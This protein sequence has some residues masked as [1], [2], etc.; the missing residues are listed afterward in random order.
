MRLHQLSVT[1]FGPFAGTEV[2]DFDLLARAG[3]FL[4]TGPTGAGKT[5]VLDAVCFALYGQVPGARSGAPLRSEH[6]SADCAT[7]VE[8]ELTIRGRRFRVQR[9][10]AWERAKRKGEGTT[11]QPAKI[12]LTEFSSQQWHTVSTRL[13]EAGQ[14]LARLIG[15]SMTQFC[16]VV[17]LPQGQFAEFLR[18]PAE[19]RREL[20]ENLFDTSRFATVEMWFVEARRA[21]ARA[22]Q[23]HDQAVH[24]VVARVAEAVQAE[25]PA[26]DL[27]P[28]AAQAWLTELIDE[29][30]ARS[31][32]AVDAEELAGQRR[33]QAQAALL[34]AEQ[35]DSA[36]QRFAAL[37][38]RRDELL[39][40]AP[41]VA[42][43][44]EEL[45]TARRAAPVVPLWTETVRLEQ[46]LA[47]AVG[48]VA[49]VTQ[50]LSAQM[51][52][53]SATLR[54]SA[55][56]RATAA[57]LRA[58]T[59]VLGQLV[60][61]EVRA[62]E[63]TDQLAEF[64][65][66]I[67]SLDTQ[68]AELAAATKDSPAIVAQLETEL[69]AARRAQAQL[70]GLETAAH[71]ANSCLAAAR[72]R[73]ELEVRWAAQ[74]DELRIAV[75]G[76]QAAR[77]LALDLRESRLQGMAAELA[78]TLADETPCCVCGSTEHPQPAQASVG[79]ATKADEQAADAL[80]ESAERA[81][82]EVLARVT[83]TE[84][85]LAEARSLAADRSV[86]DLT[87]LLAEAEAEQ[88]VAR[89]SAATCSSAEDRLQR[90]RRQQEL[91]IQQRMALDAE[92]ER[93]RERTRVAQEQLD[94]LRAQ[95]TLARGP[96]FS[97][98]ARIARIERLAAD[99]EALSDALNGAER[100]RRDLDA[101]RTRAEEAAQL[102][103]IPDLSLVPQ[104]IR[105]ERR[106]TELEEQRARHIA[107]LASVNELLADPLLQS[108]AAH[109]PIEMSELRLDAERAEVDHRQAV[110][111]RH[112]AHQ[113][114]TALSRLST[115]IET[116][117]T[118]RLPLAAHFEI[119][120][121]L[122]RLVE[123][124]STDNRLRMSLAAYVLAAR[125]E[126]VAAAASERLLAMS[127]GRYSLLHSDAASGRA[128]RGGLN[129]RVFDAWTGSDRDPAT[130]SGGESF[131]AS[132]ALALGLADVVTG[133]AGGSLLETL[134][135]DEGF[136][137]L[138]E[139]TLDDVMGL[140]DNLR[141][142]GRIIGIVSHV[143][144]LRQRV[145]TQLQIVKG[146]RGSTICQ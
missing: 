70:A 64:E 6:A 32:L 34:A 74:R 60:D 22:L 143:A 141:D 19:R 117:L 36:R 140:L 94:S 13:D 43:F 66:T 76:A 91:Q 129:L 47:E 73:D 58:E 112:G 132:L 125:L 50:G 75:D 79:A 35:L 46:V 33:Q 118:A 111:E 134:F 65:R 107:E 45:E 138:D 93:L 20:L 31:L 18:A 108:A 116:L 41:A 8:L 23:N 114:T 123:G 90:H 62:E 37:A 135:V 130:L 12:L 69:D 63:L 21:A 27:D 105:D 28:S 142:G 15:L 61:H 95:L 98:R 110:G 59:G 137:S 136:G 97:V 39:A 57:A 127:S 86:R 10:P 55:D 109:G 71:S 126:Q 119:V 89:A 88:A 24:R 40:E 72:R 121:H 77:Q 9:S 1:A 124:K 146:R 82:A 131:A 113:C 52:L 7:S 120:D 81:R 144:D 51:G 68:S 2:V 4:F 49:T 106:I 54:Q 53:S 56:V 29:A 84:I 133:E 42:A 145:P 92:T 85:G 25:Q 14:L 139:E 96:D 67:V 5:S 104:Q 128:A 100:L 11:T 115:D 101:A 16:Q 78:G 17:L 80:A 99:C 102:H 48:Q 87:A 122:S 26:E 3:L 103:G 83:K 44:V 38:A 30:R